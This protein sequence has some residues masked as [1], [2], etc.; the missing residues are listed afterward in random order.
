MRAFAA[1]KSTLSIYQ[2]HW[3]TEDVEEGWRALADARKAGKLR[4]IG[5]SNFDVAQ[6]TTIRK[7]AP[8]HSLQ[9]PYSLLSREV[10]KRSLPFALQN[11]IGVIVYSPHG[12]GP[13]QRRY[14][15][16]A[17]QQLPA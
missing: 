7:I 12:L 10:E 8:V 16:P 15:P 1:C 13:A 9:P 11:G 3:P 14:D 5:V 17:D 6:I 2:I 4:W